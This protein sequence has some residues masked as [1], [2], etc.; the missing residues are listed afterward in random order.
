MQKKD[1]KFTKF[2]EFKSLVDKDICR[3]FKA[4]RIN[5]GGEYI[6]NDFKQLCASEGIRRELIAPHKPQ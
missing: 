2:C 6:S 5:N 3:K 4:L 1:Q